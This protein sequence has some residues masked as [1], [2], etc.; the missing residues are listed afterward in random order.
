MPRRKKNRNSGSRNR[1]AQSVT[2]RTPSQAFERSLA[3]RT[4]RTQLWGKVYLGIVSTASGLFGTNITPASLGVRPGSYATLFTR[5]RII[6]LIFK[7]LQFTTAASSNQPFFAGLLDD[8]ITS[9]DI[10]IA[11]PAVLD[12][13]CS[14]SSTATSTT[15][16]VAPVAQTTFNE[17][18]WKPLR[19]PPQWYYATVEGSSS[20]PR[21]EV[22]CSLWIGSTTANVLT[23]NFEVDYQIAFEGACDVLSQP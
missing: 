3:A 20:D 18:E 13:R 15:A 4:D 12:L 16:T 23:A 2:V 14:V 11:G 8:S 21:L 1:N 17:F 9:G 7:P 19:G 5:W 6:R 22:P 10:P